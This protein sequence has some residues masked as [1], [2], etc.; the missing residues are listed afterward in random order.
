MSAGEAMVLLHGFAGRGR[1]WSAIAPGA[2]APDLHTLRPQ[3]FDGILDGVQAVAP[4]RFVLGGYSLGAR[5]ALLLALRDPSRVERLVLVSGTA[6]LSEGRAERAAA[7][8]ALAAR[9][10][11]ATPGQA[12]ELWASLPIW[13]G[14]PP[15]VR[16]QQRDDVRSHDPRVLADALSALSPGR[17]PDLWPRLPELTMPV[18]LLAGARDATYVALAERLRRTLPDATLTVVPQAGH[19]LLREAPTAVATALR[20]RGRS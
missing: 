2:V 5:L 15:H 9:I 3:T 1:S 11:E 17:M 8:D 10:R 19:A 6:G 13:A 4:P 14:D 20:P 7:D 16:A 12:A 18:T